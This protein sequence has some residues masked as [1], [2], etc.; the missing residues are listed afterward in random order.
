MKNQK[1]V[2]QKT[3]QAQL[4]TFIGVSVIAAMGVFQVVSGCSNALKMTSNG[5]VALNATSKVPPLSFKKVD[6]L[7]IQS[8]LLGI[9][10]LDANKALLFLG[11]GSSVGVELGGDAVNP[12]VMKP[13]PEPDTV[14]DGATVV[15]L[16]PNEYWSVNKNKLVLRYEK[17]GS[18]L[19]TVSADVT[20]DDKPTVV[21]A[22]RS[23]ILLRVGESYK[24]IR[25]SGKLEI[26]YEDN[27]N[28][29]GQ[30]SPMTRVVGAGIIG[31]SSFWVSDGERLVSLLIKGPGETP[32]ILSQKV[33]TVGLSAP[34]NIGFYVKEASGKVSLVGAALGYRK[35][36]GSF[37]KASET[38]SATAGGGGGGGSSSGEIA[39]ASVLKLV[40]DNCVGCHGPTASNAF[41]GATKIDSWKT[42]A[43]KLKMHLENNSMPPGGAQLPVRQSLAAYLKSVAGLDVNI[44]A[45][46]PTPSV[47]AT[48]DPKL[49]EFNSTYKTL[50]QNSCVNG[51]HTHTFHLGNEATFDRVKLAAAG[52]K[53]RLDNSSMPRAPVT[54]TAAQ[55]TMLSTWLGSLNP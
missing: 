32:T 48:P 52:M 17:E 28:F 10:F 53:A 30:A 47:T 12:K 18:G 39:D 34:T 41:K 24:L 25:I 44:A 42:S 20:F 38:G 14:A 5:S 2:F 37:F 40:Q 23:A 22:S 51:C 43:S 1:S 35:S 7:S 26:V 4:R 9:G 6:N 55:R 3:S 15:A 31:D 45:P 29:M 13:T 19:A 27:L 49:A 11:D 36:D 50:I 54:I 33:Q 8:E 16:S 46:T 21:A